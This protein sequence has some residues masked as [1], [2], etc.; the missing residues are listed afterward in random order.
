MKKKKTEKTVL[1]GI[2]FILGFFLLFPGMQTEAKVKV[3]TPV[4]TKLS[5][6]KNVITV[7][8]SKVSKAKGY[9]CGQ[10]FL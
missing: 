1:L 10:A 5:G 3:G 2:M 4:I 9:C 7:R 8:W 6:D